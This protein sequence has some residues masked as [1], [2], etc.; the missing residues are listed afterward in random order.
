MKKIE[1]TSLLNF[2]MTIYNLHH[3]KMLYN[4]TEYF[5]VYRKHNLFLLCKCQ[6]GEELDGNHKC[7][8]INEE[9]QKGY[10]ARST[11][12]VKEK[13]IQQ[14]LY[15]FNKSVGFMKKSLKYH[16][17][18]CLQPYYIKIIAAFIFLTFDIQL[19]SS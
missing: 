14:K 8:F 6:R 17:L 7:I 12:R 15:N 18:D 16:I 10:W 11:K 3:G 4:L 5:F 1:F 13:G 2:N 19:Q 9:L